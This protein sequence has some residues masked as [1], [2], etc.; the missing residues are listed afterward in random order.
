VYVEVVKAR[1]VSICI[2]D[3]RMNTHSN[4]HSN[5]HR[6]II[7]TQLCACVDGFTAPHGPGGQSCCPSVNLSLTKQIQ[8]INEMIVRTC[9]VSTYYYHKN[10]IS[11]SISLHV[12]NTTFNRLTCYIPHLVPLSFILIFIINIQC[13]FT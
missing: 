6:T 10:T 7:I 1:I 13:K 9:A 12:H 3:N 4:T 5:H 2:I 11:I 8:Y